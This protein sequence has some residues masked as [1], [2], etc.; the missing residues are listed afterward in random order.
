[1]FTLDCVQGTRFHPNRLQLA[2]H[3]LLMLANTY[4]AIPLLHT[5]VSVS[6]TSHR[7]DDPQHLH[8]NSNV[9]NDMYHV[10]KTI[11]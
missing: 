10:I 6:N 7:V 11:I 5:D 1:M 2:A 8:R 9:S 4:V 3:A